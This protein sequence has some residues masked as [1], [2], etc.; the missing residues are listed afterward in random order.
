MTNSCSTRGDNALVSPRTSPGSSPA[1]SSG[2]V[3][4]RSCRPDRSPAA[5]SCHHGAGPASPG[6][7]RTDS[8]ATVRSEP[9]GGISRPAT[10]TSWPGTIPAHSVTGAS[11]RTRPDETTGCPSTDAVRTSAVSTTD[12]APACRSAYPALRTGLGRSATTTSSFAGRPWAAAACRPSR[13]ASWIRQAIG[14]AATR[15]STS[16][17]AAAPSPRDRLRARQSS[18]PASTAAVRPTATAVHQPKSS[19]ARAASQHASAAGTRRRS[20]R[21]SVAGRALI[22]PSPARAAF[23]TCFRRCRRRRATARLS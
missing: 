10:R 19:P 12:R 6:G 9:R 3:R 1:G 13:S 4:L 16:N 20:C 2:K 15:P 21:V 8:T 14:P 18:T 17:A 23:R 5:A 7:P 22:R 11:S